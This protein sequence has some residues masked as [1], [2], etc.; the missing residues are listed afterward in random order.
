[1]NLGFTS[2][3]G[4]VFAKLAGGV[5]NDCH[6]DKIELFRKQEAEIFI[7]GNH[8]KIMN[9]ICNG[10]RTDKWVKAN[11]LPNNIQTMKE[12][13]IEETKLQYDIVIFSE[14]NLSNLLNTFSC[15]EQQEILPNNVVIVNRDGDHKPAELMSALGKRTLPWRV[16][17]D[18]LGRNIN[19]QLD[20]L[21]K[22]GLLKSQIYCVCHA[23]WSP[24]LDLFSNLNDWVADEMGRFSLVEPDKNGNGLMVPK[25][26]HYMLEGHGKNGIRS[27]IEQGTILKIDEFETS[28]KND[29]NNQ[30]CQTV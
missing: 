18:L 1:M 11:N 17:N 9:R 21:F 4:C 7:D 19:S 15:F 12:R 8:Y 23:G 27:K 3:K 30:Y 29:K 22:R 14:K 13:V 5:Q 10:R 26:V 16:I 2:C 28:D 24:P 6:M 25:Y 20:S